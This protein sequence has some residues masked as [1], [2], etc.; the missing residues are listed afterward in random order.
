MRQ[1]FVVAAT[2]LMIAVAIAIGG[3]TVAKLSPQSSSS[4]ASNSISV[5]Q[6]MKNAKNL[7]EERFDAH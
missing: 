4:T 7:P 1:T 5:M 2:A 3:N 6:L